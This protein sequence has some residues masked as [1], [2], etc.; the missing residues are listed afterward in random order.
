MPKLKIITNLVIPP[1]WM[2]EKSNVEIIK[3]DWSTA[4][5]SDSQMRDLI[6]ESRAVVIPLKDTMQPS[7]QSVCLQAMACARPVIISHNCGF[8]GEGYLK[9]KEHC[10]WV[11]CGQPEEITS[12]VKWIESSTLQA[13]QM[14]NQGQKTVQQYFTRSSMA[15][16]LTIVLR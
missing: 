14:G 8:W 2:A 6:R 12:A 3:S 4:G 15:Q 5:V 9:H 16:E 13:Q 7:G 11:S 10:Y 1:A